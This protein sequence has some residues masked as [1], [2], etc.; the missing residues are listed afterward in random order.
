MHLDIGMDGNS[1]RMLRF[2][3]ARL[4]LPWILEEQ[5]PIV[6]R[7]SRKVSN[8]A[9]NI[10]RHAAFIGCKFIGAQDNLYDHIGRH[11]YKEC[12]IEDSVDF[13]FGN[14]LSLYEDCH[15]HAITNSFAALTTQKRDNLLQETGFSFVKLQ[16]HGV[17]CPLLGHSMGHFL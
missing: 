2:R 17:W 5:G 14:G 16:G 10:G 11:Y 1:G 15:L 7:S 12:Y 9:P 4:T 6:L 8:R 3:Q 13:I